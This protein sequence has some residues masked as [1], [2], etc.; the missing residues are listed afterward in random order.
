MDA[1]HERIG[2]RGQARDTDEQM[3]A[4][5]H[6]RDRER[7]AA[8][9]AIRLDLGHQQN[10]RSE[11]DEGGERQAPDADERGRL[12]HE[13][14]R[15]ERI[16]EGVPR[17]AGEEMPAQPFGGREDGREDTAMRGQPSRPQEAR[18][19]GAERPEERQAGGQVRPPRTA[20]A[21]ELIRLDEKGRAD[22]PQ[23]GDERA[24]AES[25]ADNSRRRAAGGTA[26]APLAAV[27][28]SISQTKT[29]TVS[30][31]SGKKR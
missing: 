2:R 28:P 9:F 29:G 14:R 30:Q 22:P 7:R 18:Q 26:P 25:P 6:C 12:H 21:R 16:A 24:E 27:A 10:R 20:S 4:E 15:R 31:R 17:K 1:G 23:A 13:R 11:N 19:R 5:D 8:S 3:G